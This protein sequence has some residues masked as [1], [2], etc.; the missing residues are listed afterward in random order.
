MIINLLDTMDN[1]VKLY[2]VNSN[3]IERKKDNDDL[4]FNIELLFGNN[5]NMNN[6]NSFKD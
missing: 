5:N 2:K 6:N 4:I 1:T 3:H